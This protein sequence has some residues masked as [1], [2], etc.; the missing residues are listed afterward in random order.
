M[1]S[2]TRITQVCWL[3]LAALFAMSSAS[4]AQTTGDGNVL[5]SPADESV[6]I[7]FFFQPPG[8]SFHAP[9]IFRVVDEK[10]P[11][12]NT[13]P[14]LDSGRTA[15]IS[16]SDMQRLLPAVTHLPLLWRHAETVEVFGSSRVL[17]LVD[18]M[19][20]T[21]VSS[22]GT[23]RAAL[24]PKKI[25]ETLKPMDSAIKT[26]RALWEFQLFR[27]GYGCKVPGFNYDAYPDHWTGHS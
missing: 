26:P 27:I 4:Y 22:H 11:R 12:L 5:N 3:T 7:R 20:I 14:I 24:D 8:D 25:C 21:V 9:L 13:A 18:T 15:Y 16:L 6:A 23:A 2:T 10:D 17:Q 19:D 1:I